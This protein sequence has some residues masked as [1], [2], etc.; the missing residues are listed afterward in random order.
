MNNFILR[1]FPKDDAIWEFSDPTLVLKN[2]R[3]Y[4]KQDVYRSDKPAKKYM[5]YDPINEK[6]VYFGQM[7]YEDYTRH[8]DDRRRLNYLSRT[9]NMRGNWKN[10][11]YSANN[12]SRTL[13]W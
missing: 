8:K 3:K 13:L 12:L 11:A 4:Y 9:A 10:N 1:Y 7:G 6:M 5:I 2:A